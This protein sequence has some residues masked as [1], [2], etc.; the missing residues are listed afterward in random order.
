MGTTV[1]VFRFVSSSVHVSVLK[2]GTN[3]YQTICRLDHQDQ[4]LL[5][6]VSQC[7]HEQAA[8]VAKHPAGT[9]VR[10]ARKVQEDGAEEGGVMSQ[11]HLCHL[12]EVW[13]ET[14]SKPKLPCEARLSSARLR[15]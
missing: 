2:V 6:R 8:Q 5:L 3:T 12:K 4:Q 11:G 13:I 7:D 14:H 1:F 15:L 9:L 10:E